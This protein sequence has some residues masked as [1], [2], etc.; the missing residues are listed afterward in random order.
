MEA[1]FLNLI[2][3]NRLNSYMGL[4]D[5]KEYKFG[6]DYSYIEIPLKAAISHESGNRIK[7]VKDKPVSLI[8]AET[9]KVAPHYKVMAEIN[10][11]ILKSAH[12]SMA[13]IYD[14]GFSG[15]PVINAVFYTDVELDDY[16]YLVRLYLLPS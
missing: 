15:E 12:V 14:T 6:K 16:T 13:H 8:A 7:K 1:V 11:E 3:G 2:R 5:N 4:S 10:P 9:I